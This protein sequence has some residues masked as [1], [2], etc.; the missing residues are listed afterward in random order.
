[1]HDV[2]HDII[3]KATAQVSEEVLAKKQQKK[4]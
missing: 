1:M 2:E 4:Q 3:V